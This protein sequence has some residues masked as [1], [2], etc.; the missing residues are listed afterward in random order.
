MCCNI[1]TLLMFLN[2][3]LNNRATE[4]QNLFFFSAGISEEFITPMFNFYKSIGELHMVLEEQALL[5]TITILTPG[6]ILPSLLSSS[7]SSL[8]SLDSSLPPRSALREGP[9]C[10]REDSREHTWRAEE[11]VCAAPSAG[12]PVFRSPTGSSDG[13]EDTQPLPRRDAHILAGERSQ[14]YSSALWD[15]G[16]AVTPRTWGNTEEL[17]DKH[18]N[19]L[20][21]VI[22][23]IYIWWSGI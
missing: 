2:L 22:L 8:K 10:C 12:P 3:F 4:K 14:I 6:K 5:T 23:N 16:R 20:A 13:A 11:G 21:N 17:Q 7:Q 18:L 1:G 9:Q 15:L 19:I